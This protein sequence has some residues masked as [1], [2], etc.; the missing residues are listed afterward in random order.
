MLFVLL[1]YCI[2]LILCRT[3]VLVLYHWGILYLSHTLICVSLSTSIFPLGVFLCVH[4]SIIHTFVPCVLC[5]S[6]SISMSFFFHPL[7]ELKYPHS[8]R[9]IHVV[10]YICVC[11]GLVDMFAYS[12]SPSTAPCIIVCISPVWFRQ[13]TSSTRRCMLTRSSIPSCPFPHASSCM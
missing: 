11:S 13:F 2:S 7:F 12:C 5:S 3:G 8:C 9:A 1:C 4:I 10:R 6:P